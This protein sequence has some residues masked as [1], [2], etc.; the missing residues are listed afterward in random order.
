MVIT[1]I[2]LWTITIIL[3]VN[4]PKSIVMRWGAL[5]TFCG[6]CGGF[7]RA[8]IETFVPYLKT[9]NLVTVAMD[10]MFYKI[11]SAGS[12][13]NTTGLPYAFLM[14]SVYY[15]GY[16][17]SVSK[18]LLSWAAAAPIVVMFSITTFYPVLN[19]NYEIL[20]LWVGPYIIFGSILLV[21]SYFKEKNP[22]LKRSRLLANSLALPPVLFQ[23]FSNYI[24]RLFDFHEAWRF[25]AV[26][27][28][29]LFV[30]F[31][32]YI[33]KYDV[34]GIK[35]KFE[36][37][38]LDSTIRALTSG[39]TILNHTIKNEAGKIKVLAEQA[40]E[41]IDP[42]LVDLRQD[43]HSIV[44]SSEH[45]LKMVHHIQNQMQDFILKREM[46][47]LT[48]IIDSA[49]AL[50][51]PQLDRKNINLVKQ[52]RLQV[53]MMCDSLLLQEVF[54]NILFNAIEAMKKGGKITIDVYEYKKRI[55]VMI[56]DNGIGISKVNMPYIFDPFF[57]SKKQGNNFGLGLSYCYNVVQ[58]HGGQI[59]IAS[60]ENNGTAISIQFPNKKVTSISAVKRGVKL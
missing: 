52:Y 56:K 36:R 20:I 48:E 39:T 40:I 5:I 23:L 7:A 29:I 49:L 11:Y 58:K 42:T 30:F 34:F 10:P 50:V 51:K 14:F 45:L 26:F 31:I 41:E 46:H 55:V 47:E 17:S 44:S 35:L 12:F 38:R 4:A 2:A 9:Y 32:V 60:E 25:N 27:I 19:H 57:S 13:I 21:H 22:L 28:A 8:L 24:L 3:L 43:I 59:N 1:F 15:S 16:F 54:I 6:G 18:R 53:N 33:T 37:Q